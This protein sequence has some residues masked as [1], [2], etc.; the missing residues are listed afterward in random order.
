MGSMISIIIPIYNAEDHLRKCIQSIIDQE[1]KNLEIILVND[2]STDS[3][4]VICDEFRNID[5]RI[6][7]IHKE[8]EGTSKTRQ[9]GIE[10]AKGEYITFVDSD[11]YIH[12]EMYQRLIKEIQ[13]KQADIIECG[14]N[15]VSEEGSTI[16]AH[17]LNEQ[18]VEGNYECALFFARK[19]NV[20][21]YLWNKLF[22]ASLFYDIHYPS[23]SLGEDVY[24]I[25]QLFGNA[26]RV[27]TTDGVYYNYVMT[28]D[29]LVRQPFTK[30]KF[31]SI[32]AGKH[33][34]D[35]Y[36]REYPDLTD[37]AALYICSFVA[38]IYHQVG[39]SKLENKKNM[40]SNLIDIFN[41]Y[42]SSDILK[43]RT[44]DISK[45]RWGLI[46]CFKIS[47]SLC[48]F[49]IKLIGLFKSNNIK[50]SIIKKVRVKA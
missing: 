16:K 2:G 24:I 34:Y 10:I 39:L 3:S 12:Q 17:K 19:K 23:L 49:L 40:R 8:N 32:E 26:E 4:K 50:N 11:D 47:P 13:D 45:K 38:R 7:V 48:E 30:K 33:M 21:N 28:R 1:Y 27:I 31:D 18:V 15:L 14:F 9:T 5:S 36:K 46:R 43:R 25:T 42:Y 44:E 22:K 35:Y 37:Y 29:S 6:K 41:K 20:T